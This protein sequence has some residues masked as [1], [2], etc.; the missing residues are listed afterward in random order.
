MLRDVSVCLIGNTV[1]FKFKK[2]KAKWRLIHFITKLPVTAK[3]GF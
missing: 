2:Q 3:F 1:T